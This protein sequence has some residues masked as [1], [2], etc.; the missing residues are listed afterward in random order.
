MYGIFSGW[1]IRLKYNY[2][3][4]TEYPSLFSFHSTSSSESSFQWN[5]LPTPELYHSKF[6]ILKCCPLYKDKRHKRTPHINVFEL[7]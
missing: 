4:L 5:L 2:A 6:H 7:F 3:K 1:N